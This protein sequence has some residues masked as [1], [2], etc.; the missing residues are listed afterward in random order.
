MRFGCCVLRIPRTGR[1]LPHSVR[2]NGQRPGAFAPSLQRVADASWRRN[3]GLLD[4]DGRTGGFKIL[5][6][7]LGFFLGGAFLDDAAGLG[8]VLGFLQAEA[9]DRRGRP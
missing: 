3:Y 6:D 5:L 1:P 2:Y 7:L 8:Q 4:F 9:G